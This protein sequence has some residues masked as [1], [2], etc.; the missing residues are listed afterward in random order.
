MAFGKREHGNSRPVEEFVSLDRENFA[1]S[2]I[3]AVAVVKRNSTLRSANTSKRNRQ[4]KD[5]LSKARPD[6]MS[7]QSCSSRQNWLFFL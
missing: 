3:M 6:L 4:S 1:T 5:G 2:A 7:A